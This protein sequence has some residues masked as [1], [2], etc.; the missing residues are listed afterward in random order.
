MIFTTKIKVKPSV[1]LS[2]EG[3]SFNEVDKRKFLGIYL[4]NKINWKKR[5]YIYIYV[6]KLPME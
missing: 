6:E 1:A 3:H 5:I 2:I 4:D